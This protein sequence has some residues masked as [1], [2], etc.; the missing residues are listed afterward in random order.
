MFFH[1]TMQSRYTDLC[2]MWRSTT[3]LLFDPSPHSVKMSSPK[4]RRAER[5]CSM[6][7]KEWTTRYFF[8]E[9][10]QIWLVDKAL[11]VTCD[12]CFGVRMSGVQVH[13]RSKKQTMRTRSKTTCSAY[14]HAVTLLCPFAGC[15]HVFE[16]GNAHWIGQGRLLP[17][18][19]WRQSGREWW[20]WWYHE[21]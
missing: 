5:E 10:R 8:T 17:L 12:V 21:R 18:V 9:H 14:W 15:C 16:A 19:K 4:K 20:S 3:P 6:F 11:H 13:V 7:N 1:W 2:W